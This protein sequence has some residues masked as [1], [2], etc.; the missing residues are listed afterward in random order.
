MFAP[1]RSGKQRST[2]PRFRA[3]SGQQIRQ[4]IPKE[5]VPLI[6]KESG[7][8]NANSDALSDVEIKV[9]R[10]ALQRLTEEDKKRIQAQTNNLLLGNE[11]MDHYSRDGGHVETWGRGG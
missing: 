4:E 11:W 8:Q 3:T 7:Q 6:T 5:Y 1:D 2:S 9:L 10:E